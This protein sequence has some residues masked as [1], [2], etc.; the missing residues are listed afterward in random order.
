[1]EL[2]LGRRPDW[3]SGGLPGDEEWRI[4]WVK[5]YEG[6]DLAHAFEV[7]G[8]PEFL[9][10]WEDLVESFCEQV[11]VGHDSSDVSARRLQNWLYAWSALRRRP[12]LPRPAGGLAR[13]LAER[14]RADA[15]HLAAHL[16][17]ARNHRTLELYTLLL[18]PPRPRPGLPRARAADDILGLLGRNAAED[19][20]ADGVHRECSHATIT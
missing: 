12:G 8:D 7:T 3:L 18:V 4:E 11:P 13:R 17:P 6:L 16:T 1:M 15:D 19:I 14:I 5:L 9:R 20:W 2:D 10:T